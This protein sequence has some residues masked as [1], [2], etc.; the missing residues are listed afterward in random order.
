MK[1]AYRYYEH[2]IQDLLNAV[3]VQAAEDYREYSVRVMMKPTDLTAKKEIEAIRQFFLS[4][5]FE[6]YT[7]AEGAF[8][9]RKLEEEERQMKALVTEA[10]AVK[11]ALLSAWADYCG[12]EK[13][14]TEKLR[15]VSFCLARLQEIRKSLPKAAARLIRTGS[16]EKE[17]RREI[18]RRKR[19][20]EKG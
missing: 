1:T 9:L 17:I 13:R 11:E 5:E 10:N 3:V 6:V 16:K 4:P 19:A 7:T 12:S 8:I 20:Y 15:D 2:A 14:D 18:I